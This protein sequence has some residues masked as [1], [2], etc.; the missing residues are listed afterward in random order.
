MKRSLRIAALSALLLAAACAETEEGADDGEKFLMWYF[1][2]GGAEWIRIN[3][4]CPANLPT[5]T[6]GSS[7]NVTFTADFRGVDFYY[8]GAT[9]ATLQAT[10]DPALD[11]SITRGFCA[12]PNIGTAISG[13]N[14]GGAGVT[15]TLAI[16]SGCSL[17]RLEFLRVTSRL[18]N[19]GVATISFF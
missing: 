10:P 3:A 6:V 15:E 1:W 9:S 11:M 8:C 16:P 18:G 4:P 17:D 19:T 2:G 13:A 5:Y 14:V 12:G 7:F